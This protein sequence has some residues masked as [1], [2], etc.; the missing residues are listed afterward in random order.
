MTRDMVVHQGVPR[1]YQTLQEVDIYLR[2]AAAAKETIDFQDLCFR[3]VLDVFVHM[4]F[5][6][7][8]DC[9]KNQSKLVPFMQAFNA[10]QYL[11]HVS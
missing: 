9:V 10:L 1:V 7:E 2:K 11:S 3:M 4:T 5:G 6:V 8:L